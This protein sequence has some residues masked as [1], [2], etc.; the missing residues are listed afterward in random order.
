[1]Y[2]LRGQAAGASQ[3]DSCSGIRNISEISGN[4]LSLPCPREF[5][6]GFYPQSNKSNHI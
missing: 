1:M 5:A 2:G 3:P 4:K 6:T